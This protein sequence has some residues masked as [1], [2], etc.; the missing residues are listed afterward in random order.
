MEFNITRLG[1]LLNRKFLE[2]GKKYLTGIG[3][4]TGIILAI[5]IVSMLSDQAYISQFYKMALF[6]YVIGG[7]IVS[8][9][10]FTEIN[11]PETGYQFMTL[12]ASSLEKFMSSWLFTSIVYSIMA[13]VVIFIGALLLA[14]L[15]YFDLPVQGNVFEF[16]EM[17]EVLIQYLFANTLFLAGAAAFNRNAFFKTLLFLLVLFFFLG[18]YAGSLTKVFGLIDLANNFGN[19]GFSIN[20]NNVGH[21]FGN[22]KY[23]GAALQTI[24][25]LFFLVVGFFK[26]KE[27]EL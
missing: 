2:S 17:S 18:I 26:F 19:V 25:A 1:L 15:G 14:L 27:R 12:P 11:K 4:G 16:G 22:W 10:A 21:F 7:I 23:T 5:S 24:T 6:T 3:I 8:T 9:L 20:K 13:F